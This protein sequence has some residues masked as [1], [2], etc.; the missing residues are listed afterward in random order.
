MALEAGGELDERV[1]AQEAAEGGVVQAA[2]HVDGAGGVER[3]V[4]GE[5]AVGGAGVEGRGGRL[6]ERGPVRRV[7]PLPPGPEAHGLGLGA[8]GVGEPV[9]A[10]EVVAQ[11]VA[12]GVRFA[13]A[14]GGALDL[15][16]GPADAAADRLR[17][18]GDG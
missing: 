12:D 4:A 7:P 9:H 17:P 13:A 3:L 18:V 15:D 11:D 1:G 14:P 16:G 10:A 5:A 2:V 6:G 8:G